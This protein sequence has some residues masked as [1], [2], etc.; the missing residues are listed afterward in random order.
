MPRKSPVIRLRH[1]GEV[2]YVED[3]EPV[4]IPK[5]GVYIMKCCGCGLIHTVQLAA[6]GSTVLPILLMRAWRGRKFK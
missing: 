6:L 3:G 1:K 5:D 2:K 4:V